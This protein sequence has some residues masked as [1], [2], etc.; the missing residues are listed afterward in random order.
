MAGTPR[1]EDGARGANEATK[2]IK[3]EWWAKIVSVFE[4]NYD[5]ENSTLRN[6]FEEHDV[7]V[8]MRKWI[9]GGGFTFGGTKWKFQVW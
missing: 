2:A 6:F 3:L 1:G 8:D 4:T 7:D 9:A 5:F